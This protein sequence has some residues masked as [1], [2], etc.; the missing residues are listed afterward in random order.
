MFRF[1]TASRN[2]SEQ[3]TNT[4]VHYISTFFSLY[5]CVV[6]VSCV[7]HLEGVG[8]TYV[9]IQVRLTVFTIYQEIGGIQCW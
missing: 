2:W 8:L 5:P 4:T 9:V 1:D 3:L 7:R 6:I